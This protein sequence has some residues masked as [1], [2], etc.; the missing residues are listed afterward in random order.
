MPVM[1]DSCVYLDVFTQDSQWFTWSSQTLA[2]VVNRGAVVLN[3]AIYA[4][5]SVRFAR[6][7]DLEA[8]LPGD[9]FAYHPIPRE[10]AFLA[11]KCYLKHHRRQ[12]SKATPLPGFFIGVHAAVAKLELVTRDPRRFQ[13]YFPTVNLITP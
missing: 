2:A 7:E 8:L 5:I 6:V 10:A 3:P 4:E 9:S 12:G 11:G 1:V 13:T